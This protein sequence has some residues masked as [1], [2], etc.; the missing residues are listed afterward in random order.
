MTII[1]APDL[2]ANPAEQ[3]AGD[4]LRMSA[5]EFLRWEHTGAALA[6]IAGP[7]ALIAA[8]KPRA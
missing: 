4:P 8:F 2:R 3:S 6:A 5:E 7:E 1:R